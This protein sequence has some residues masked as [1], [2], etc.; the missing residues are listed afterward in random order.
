MATP[1]QLPELPAEI[2]EKI[3]IQCIEHL[4]VVLAVVVI[5]KIVLQLGQ[6]KGNKHF[7]FFLNIN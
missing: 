5:S 2:W 7:R 3:L 6:Q 4:T 1:V